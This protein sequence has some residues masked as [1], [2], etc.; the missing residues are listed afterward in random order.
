[1]PPQLLEELG[2]LLAALSQ[3][4]GAPIPTIRI[5]PGALHASVQGGVLSLPGQHVSHWRRFGV[6]PTAL[7]RDVAYSAKREQLLRHGGMARAQVE[8]DAMAYAERFLRAATDFE[9]D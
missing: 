8:A 1:L 2:R 6:I 4:L 9:D 7:V 5:L 3:D